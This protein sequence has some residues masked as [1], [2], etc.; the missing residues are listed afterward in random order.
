MITVQS[1]YEKL[2]PVFGLIWNDGWNLVLCSFQQS[3][4][5]VIKSGTLDEIYQ[6]IISKADK[7]AIESRY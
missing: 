2:P 5:V 4:V 1:I 7:Y 6:F 3:A